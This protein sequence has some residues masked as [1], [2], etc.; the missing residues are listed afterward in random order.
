M[1]KISE[2]DRKMNKRLAVCLPIGLLV[3]ASLLI[4]LDRMQV[5]EKIFLV[6]YEGPVFLIPEIT[7]IDDSSLKSDKYSEESHAMMV[8]N[9]L[10]E[11]EEPEEPETAEAVRSEQRTKKLEK[12][13]TDDIQELDFIRSYP[14]HADIPYSEEYVILKMVKPAYPLDA[15]T[16]GLE[17]YILVEVYVN[18][19]GSVARAYIRSSYGPKSF[20]SSTLE[21][22]NQFL[23]KPN[24]EKGKRVPFWISFLVRFELRT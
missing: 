7:I 16:K 9:V 21:A 6:G 3:I 19:E 1:G 23:F 13:L 8:K 14:K 2:H 24:I 11:N 18:E 15:L 12:V 20:E 10:L 5:V 17:G 4:G 22:V